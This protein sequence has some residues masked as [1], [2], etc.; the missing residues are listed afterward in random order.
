MHTFLFVFIRGEYAADNRFSTF[1]EITKVVVEYVI[2]EL[3]QSFTAPIHSFYKS[4]LSIIIQK[5]RCNLKFL[6]Y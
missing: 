6:H 3:K 5:G 1:K 4:L 2:E